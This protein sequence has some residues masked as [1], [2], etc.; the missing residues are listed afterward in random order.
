M[1]MKPLKPF[2]A[3]LLVDANDTYMPSLHM[4]K[5]LARSEIADQIYIRD[6]AWRV[7]RVKVVPKSK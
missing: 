1:K 4:T 5:A 7:V 3:W 2:D 6:A